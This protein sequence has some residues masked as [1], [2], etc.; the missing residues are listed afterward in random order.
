MRL[1]KLL[2][3]YGKDNIPFFF[4]ISYDLK[5]F[6]VEPLSSL[7][8]D[9]E[10]I[11]DNSV[12]KNSNKNIN[13]IK[14]KPSFKEYEKKFKLVQDNLKKGNSYLLNLTTPTNISTTM[15]LKQIYDVSYSKFKLR[16]KDDF[17]CFSPERFIKIED[18]IIS[19]YPMK[20][21]IDNSIKNALE[22]ILN[23]P[24]ELAEHTMI[25]DLLRNDL[26]IVSKNVKVDMFRYSEVINAGNKELLQFSSKISGILD[27]NWSNNIGDILISLLPAGS[28]T[29]TPKKNTIK[30]IDEIEN[31]QR[32]FYTGIFGVY[33]GSSIDS[34]VMIRFIEKNKD[35]SFVYKSGGGITCDSSL[36][37]EYKELISK[38]Y[39]PI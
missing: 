31:Y 6:V 2:N 1:K 32:G 34:S 21:T 19:T 9:I 17:V 4:M 37:H 23:D 16:F 8:K 33:D 24:K 29:G 39:I 3:R 10:F 7:D 27:D 18:N 28:I 13:I 11:L 30:L 38:I 15:S 12:L 35:G 20:G 22:K 5:D 14:D 36:H 25:V 26:S